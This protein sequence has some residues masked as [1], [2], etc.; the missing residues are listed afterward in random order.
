MGGLLHPAR[1]RTGFELGFHPDFHAPNRFV[2]QIG[3]SI[4]ALRQIQLS[5]RKDFGI[6]FIGAEKIPDG[7][8]VALSAVIV[9]RIMPPASDLKSLRGVP[10][11]L[12]DL[13]ISVFDDFSIRFSIWALPIH[14]AIAR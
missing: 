10:G 6:Q 11:D 12:D 2:Q 13:K 1:H 9:R 5:I 8:M 7:K 14:A 4:A 3:N